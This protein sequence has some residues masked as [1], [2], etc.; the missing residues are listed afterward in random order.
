MGDL[1]ELTP[2]LNSPNMDVVAIHGLNGHYMD[3]WK[4][5]SGVMW[6]RDLLPEK[7][8]NA[9]IMTFKYDASVTSMSTSSVRD[10]ANNLMQSL[11][12]KRT[13]PDQ[14]YADVPI[15]FVGHSLG[16]IVIKQ[17]LVL[18]KDDG[19]FPDITRNTKGLV[20][21]GTPHRG[22]DLAQWAVLIKKIGGAVI[23]HP[24]KKLLKTLQTHSDELYKI[25]ED[26]CPVSSKYAIFSFY[27][28]N[29]YLIW[30]KVVV[31][32]DSAVM[33]LPNEDKMMIRGTHTSMCRFSR[34][35][36]RFDPVWIRIQR[37]AGGVQR[38]HAT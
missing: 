8:P 3:T 15:V 17:A 22:A 12:D 21:L 35:D 2:Q 30:G 27:E 25:T 6:L 13:G 5:K 29:A 4:E 24:D 7:L 14:K 18:A 32:K 38:Q 26:F 11:F 28:E 34:D 23:N 16:G 33:G 19:R 10:I 20:F 31:D 1:Y 9:R 36:R 37:A